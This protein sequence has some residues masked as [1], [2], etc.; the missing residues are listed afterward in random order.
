LPVARFRSRIPVPVEELFAW[1]SRPGAFER[2]TP[3]WQRVDVINRTGTIH[4]DDV[5]EMDFHAGP[6]SMRWI[7]VHSD[8]IQNRQFRDT[9]VAGPFRVWIHTHRTHADASGASILD[10]EVDYQ[11]PLE[12]VVRVP[13]GGVIHRE[14]RRLFRYRHARTRLDLWRHSQYSHAPRL[15]IAVVGDHPLAGQLRAFF[16]GGGHHLV[17]S[18]TAAAVVDLTGLSR[19]S[20]RHTPCS[21]AT[22]IVRI[23]RAAGGPALASDGMRA[24]NLVIPEDVVGGSFAGGTPLLIVY[25]PLKSVLH[26]ANHGVWISEDDLIGLVYHALLSVD[27]QGEFVA[28][29][30]SA[31]EVPGFTVAFRTRSAAGALIAGRL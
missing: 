16:G 25:E 30:A 8:Y 2:L 12:Q 21:A 26:R 6:L 11:V 18:D 23:S 19:R 3:P 24:T 5:L 14:L 4:D 15:S 13:L 20:V 27:V 7:A 10:D 17:A 22:S 31:R 9:Q 28:T 29:A 1:H